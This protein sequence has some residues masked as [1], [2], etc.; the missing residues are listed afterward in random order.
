MRLYGFPGSASLVVRLLLEETQQPY[1]FVALDGAKQ[2]HKQPAYLKLNPHGRVPTLVDGETVLYESAAI[3]LY[4]AEKTQG[5]WALPTDPAQR[6]QLYKWLMFLTNSVQ[7]A[8]VAYFYP[9]RLIDLPDAVPAVKTK[10]EANTLALFRQIDAELG[11]AGPYLLG[12]E[13]TVVDL[14]LLM[15]VR[16]GRWFATPAV[17]ACPNLA[18]LVAGLSA[19]PAVQRT[20]ELEGIPAPYCLLPQ[21]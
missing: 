13:P 10:A 12:E 21:G 8:L 11:A 6:G 17:E 1:E 15:L 7:P 2:E 14:F 16:W 20:F 5:P 9:D 18:R 19:R 4:L 3:C